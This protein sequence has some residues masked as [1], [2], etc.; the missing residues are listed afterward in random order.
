MQLNKLDGR[1]TGRTWFS[2]YVTSSP[3]LSAREIRIQEFI[4]WRNWCQE[5]FGPGCERNWA[6][7]Y[8]VVHGVAPRWGWI[9][10]ERIVG[11]FPRLYLATEAEVSLFTLKWG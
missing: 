2:H 7:N 5:T 10:D 8:R 6:T 3:T 4:N 11:T 9:T 1:H